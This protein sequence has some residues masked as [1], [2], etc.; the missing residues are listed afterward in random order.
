MRARNLKP[1]FFRNEHL[2]SLPFEDRLLFAGLWCLSD[3]DGYFENRPDRIAADLFPYDK[4]IDG[5]K[6]MVMLTRLMSRGEITLH[7][8]YGYVPSFLE[9]NKPHPNETKSIVSEETKNILKNL[10]NCKDVPRYEAIRLNPDCLNPDCLNPKYPIPHSV[11]GSLCI[12]FEDFWKAYP[13]KK[14]KSDAEKAW[15]KI[16]PQNGL[17]E[18]ILAAVESQKLTEDWRKDGGR[19]IPYPATWL[20]GKRWADELSV[21][22]LAVEKNDLNLCAENVFRDSKGNPACKL[23]YG[24][25]CKSAYLSRCPKQ[26]VIEKCEVEK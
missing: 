3:R 8:D 23:E 11:T 15:K 13:K 19:F 7:G 5:R 6:I 1:G 14:S 25:K 18:T 21:V 20:N 17:S 2:G 9:H 10:C 22:S 4:K 24:Y 16:N 12:T 26:D